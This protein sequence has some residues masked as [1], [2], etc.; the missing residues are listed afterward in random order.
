MI[1]TRMRYSS[2]VAKPNPR[3]LNQIENGS[4]G[5]LKRLLQKASQFCKG[6]A[7]SSDKS[8]IFEA[9]SGSET[10]EF[11]NLFSLVGGGVIKGVADGRLHVRGVED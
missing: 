4:N 1:G 3:G 5:M 7:F 8:R 2:L 10:T 9:I 6:S 11:V